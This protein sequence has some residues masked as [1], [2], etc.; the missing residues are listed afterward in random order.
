[1][2]VFLILPKYKCFELVNN[3]NFS[4]IKLCQK[5]YSNYLQLI[6]FTDFQNK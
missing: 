5:D 1:M 4:V 3:V 6:I 2:D